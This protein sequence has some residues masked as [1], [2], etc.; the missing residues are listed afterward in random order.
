MCRSLASVWRLTIASLTILLGAEMARG[1]NGACNSGVCCDTCP[2]ACHPRPCPPPL[3]HQQEGPPRIH[4][5]RGCP[6]PICCPTNLPHYGY[7]QVGW[8][9][10]SGPVNTG[11]CPPPMTV[12]TTTIGSEPILNPLPPGRKTI[13]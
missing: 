7:Y 11:Q 1:Q 3:R 10:W 2:T 8:T 9:K 5:R 13:D 6:K 4:I 12:R